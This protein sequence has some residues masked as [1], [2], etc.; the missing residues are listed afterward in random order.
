MSLARRVIEKRRMTEARSKDAPP[1]TTGPSGGV[2][3]FG[4]LKSS[5]PLPTNK[6]QNWGTSGHRTSEKAT[7]VHREHMN[8]GRKQNTDRAEVNSHQRRRKIIHGGT[9]GN[10]Y[11][12]PEVRGER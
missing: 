9:H 5:T 8:S 4:N 7:Q 11:E 2:S 6:N 12:P 3:S 1:R 10:S